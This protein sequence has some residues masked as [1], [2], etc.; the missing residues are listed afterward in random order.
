MGI[1]DT[2]FKV[3]S[4]LKPL[5]EFVDERKNYEFGAVRYTDEDIRDAKEWAEMNN[6]VIIIPCD[7]LSELEALWTEWCSQ[8]K[9][10]R[11]ESDWKSE[12]Y[13]GLINQYHYEIL[14]DRFLSL[15]IN[16]PANDILDEAA[17]D[18]DSLETNGVSYSPVDVENAIDWSKMNDVPIIHPTRSLED[19]EKLWDNYNSYHK[20][21]RRESDWKSIE[22]FGLNNQSHYEYLKSQF[23]KDDIPETKVEAAPIGDPIRS[24][25]GFTLN[26]SVDAATK[27][28]DLLGLLG[29][30]NESYDNSI[31][32]EI[33]DIATELYA[34]SNQN[35]HYDIIPNED[36]PFFS[37]EEMIDAGVNQANPEDNFYGCEPAT[38]VLAEGESYSDWLNNYSLSCNGLAPFDS[39]GWMNKI[40]NLSL[41]MKTARDKDPY[42]QALLSLGWPAEVE[43]SPEN[44]IIATKRTKSL[45]S[46]KVGSTEFIDLTGFNPTNADIH[47]S[48]E[49]GLLKPVY[50]VL[51]GGKTMFSKAIKDVTHS[52]YSHASISFDPELKEMYS[53]GIEGSKKGIIGGFIKEDIKDA[54]GFQ[55]LE[56]YSIFLKKEDWENLKKII[57]DF[58]KNTGKTSYSY[59]N[60]I[61]SHIFKIPM[62]LSRKMVCSQF[63]DKVLKLIDVDISNKKSS[64]VSPADI[65]K[66]GRDNKKIY[67][68]F[69]GKV[70]QF[71]GNRV[72]KLTDW[73]LKK[74][75]AEPIKEM[76]TIELAHFMINEMNNNIDSI[77]ESDINDPQIKK[78]YEA[79]IK[80]CLEAEC[81]T[82][83]EKYH[84]KSDIDII[85]SLIPRV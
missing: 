66:Y 62:E 80:P 8:T 36:L 41:K 70:D 48:V 81:Y 64:L 78:I 82:E 35:I 7:S 73:L 77:K 55:P 11:R 74:K 47:E 13:F 54:E 2:N 52:N 25:I 21:I 67:T 4:Y 30:N 6:R 3:G 58:I 27:A 79:F 14:K 20:D 5:N 84:R 16:Y 34:G 68:L 69:Q 28:T 37:P 53:Y 57:N 22:C 56:V 18:N 9:K 31:S 61:V 50:I 65:D 45:L 12:E 40:A 39:I 75:V 46:D 33:V 85:E 51:I 29:K 63:V 42:K 24:H 83:G 76:N 1:L 71:Q 59:I 38:D 23:L 10:A 43:F 19:L 32:R 44:R 17:L 15:D 60:L 72:K 49:E 26:E